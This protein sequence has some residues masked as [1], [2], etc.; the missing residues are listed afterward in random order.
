MSEIGPSDILCNCAGITR[1]GWVAKLDEKAWDSV[2]DVNL[3][4]TF[5]MSQAFVR[6][7]AKAASGVLS[8]DKRQQ[9]QEGEHQ[10]QPHASGSII[11]I[12]S[13]VGKMGNLG[14]S[15]YSASKAGVI[16][17]T[18]SMAKELAPMGIRVNVVLP[19][20]IH[21]PMSDAVPQKVLD[22]LIPVIPLHRMGESQEIA[23]TV[24]FL[25]SDRSSYVTGAVVEVTGGLGM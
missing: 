12:S 21:T 8:E 18:K 16:G 3:K 15:N 25:A 5:L 1:D 23:D 7:R 14:Q 9:Q 22:K 2:I 20:F 19:G 17:M 24:A 4:G 11:N 13:V 10:Q 6:E